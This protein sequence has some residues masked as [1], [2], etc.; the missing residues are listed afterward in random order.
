M[1]LLLL[2]LG[3]ALILAHDLEREASMMSRERE[4]GRESKQERKF[5]E[6]EE[7]RNGSRSNEEGKINDL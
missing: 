1:M 6:Q 5:H 4:N 3:G 7:I 2:L